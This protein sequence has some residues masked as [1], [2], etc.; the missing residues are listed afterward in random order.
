MSGNQPL[1]GSPPGAKRRSLINVRLIVSCLVVATLLA[2]STTSPKNQ[3]QSQSD[4]EAWRRHVAEI[5]QSG[6]DVK[7][8]NNSLVITR[9]EPVTYYN[10][11]GL[12]AADDNL[13]KQMIER[14]KSPESY[15]ITVD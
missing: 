5:L 8:V 10:S 14:G 1:N 9:K 11:I 6:W 3:S 2:C 13:R 12:P 7:L 15:Q 4:V